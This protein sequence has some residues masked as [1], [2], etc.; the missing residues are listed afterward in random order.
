MN[1]NDMKELDNPLS[2][3]EFRLATITAE[4]SVMDLINADFEKLQLAIF[5]INWSV[6]AKSLITQFGAPA[7]KLVIHVRELYSTQE[8][9]DTC[10]ALVNPIESIIVETLTPTDEVRSVLRFSDLHSGMMQR[11]ASVE[12]TEI[13]NRIFTYQFNGFTETA[14]N[15]PT[16]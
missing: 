3:H 16:E 4:S 6:Y 15:K 2:Q 5:Q 8:W 13:H 1:I 7:G 9:F 12:S 10:A 14:A 11:K